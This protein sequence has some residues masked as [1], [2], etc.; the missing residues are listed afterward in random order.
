VRHSVYGKKLGRNKNQR[1]ALFKALVSSLILSESIQTT[2]A[3]AQAIKGMVDKIITQAKNPTSRRFVSQFLT[4]KRVTDKLINNLLPR[5][6]TRNSGYTSVVKL[7]PR[8]G[9]GAMLVQMTLL[10]EAPKTVTKPAKPSSALTEKAKK[11]TDKV[12]ATAK[13]KASTKKQDPKEK[14]GKKTNR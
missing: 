13:V 5:L 12:E 2:Q 7:G 1:T 14:G 10:A 9:D 4:D 8:L 11:A 6:S 3:K